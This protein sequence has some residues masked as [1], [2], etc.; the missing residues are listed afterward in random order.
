MGDG[1]AL[2]DVAEGYVVEAVEEGGG[3]PVDTADAD[4]A[5]G[6]AAGCG[7]CAAGGVT[8]GGVADCCVAHDDDAVGAC[9]AGASFCGVGADGV[10]DGAEDGLVGG[11]YTEGGGVEARREVGDGVDVYA[12]GAVGEFDGAG[13]VFDGGAQVHAGGFEE[14]CAVAEAAEGVVVAGAEDDVHAGAHEAGECLVEQGGAFGGGDGAVVDVAADEEGVDAFGVHVVE[15]FVDELL[16][17]A[18]E[19]A[20]VEGAAEVP[21]GGVQDLHGFSMALRLVLRLT[22]RHSGAEPSAQTPPQRRCS[23]VAGAPSSRRPGAAEGALPREHE[24]KAVSV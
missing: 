2:V 13:G 6:V 14:G 18:G 5:F 9:A 17:F 24:R 12:Q 23:C 8:A 4:V 10:G 20:A 11:V 19:G 7:V 22:V 1:V 3:Y 21:V 15:Q 16:V